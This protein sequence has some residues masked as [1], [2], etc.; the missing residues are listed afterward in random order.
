M[1]DLLVKES[2]R[3]G[4]AN[5]EKPVSDAASFIGG[6]CRP[7]LPPGGFDYIPA[8][9]DCPGERAAK[10]VSRDRLCYN[11]TQYTYKCLVV[12]EFIKVQL[13]KV[14]VQY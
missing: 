14:N 1:L 4:K 10:V 11:N 6:L 9:Y 12:A 5:R 8:V 3:G 7:S 13:T 2:K